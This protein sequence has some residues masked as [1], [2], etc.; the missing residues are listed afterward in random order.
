MHVWGCLFEVRDYNPQ[1]KKLDPRTINGYFVGYAKN[2]KAYRF[3]CPSHS[4]KFVESRNAKFLENDLAS[5][6][7]L[8]SERE[9]HST[10]SER[11][12]IIQNFPHVQMGVVQPIIKDP[13]TIVGNSTD[14]A[15][16]EIPDMV[17]QLVGQLNPHG[18]VDPTLRRFIRIRR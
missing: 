18:K 10:S 12:V 8:F 1:E 5:G 17:E 15:I 9:Q 6:S 2:S 4:L 7:D 3:Y 11:L 16:H 14:Q 13:Q